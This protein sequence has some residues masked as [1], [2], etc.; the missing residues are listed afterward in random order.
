[1]IVENVTLARDMHF[2]DSERLECPES[3]GTP[4]AENDTAVQLA[5]MIF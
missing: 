1:M 5:G 2:R 3:S 4:V